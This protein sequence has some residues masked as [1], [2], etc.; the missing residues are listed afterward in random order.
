ALHGE[1]LAAA[2]RLFAATERAFEDRVGAHDASAKL[3]GALT[4]RVEAPLRL[5][6][7]ELELVGRVGLGV[8]EGLGGLPGDAELVERV[9]EAVALAGEAIA[10][11]TELLELAGGH[12]LALVEGALSALSRLDA[13]LEH[14][15]L[16][17]HLVG[18]TL[19]A[20]DLAG[21]RFDRGALGL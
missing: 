13:P 15:D 5:G 16:V 6:G 19:R 20:L 14:A 9:E 8:D 2:R 7:G 18:E 10:L 3:T 11:R 4:K 17:V 21:E 1:A 12:P